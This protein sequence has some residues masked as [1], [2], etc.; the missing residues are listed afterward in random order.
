MRWMTAERQH[1]E[2]VARRAPYRLMTYTSPEVTVGALARRRF[3]RTIRKW[4]PQVIVN[5]DAVERRL[6][7][8]T[9]HDLSLSGAAVNIRALIAEVER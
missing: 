1:L 3:N 6:L 4:Y 2:R 9:Y 7:S 8:T 5:Y